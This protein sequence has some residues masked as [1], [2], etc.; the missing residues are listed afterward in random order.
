MGGQ[1]HEGGGA[2]QGDVLE[3]AADRENGVVRSA[4]LLRVL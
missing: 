3:G 1:G 2:P 4:T